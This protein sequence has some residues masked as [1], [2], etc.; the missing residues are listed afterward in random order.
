V[1]TWLEPQD[2]DLDVLEG[3][4]ALVLGYGNQGRAFA[5]N[6]RDS[7]LFE[8]VRV[9]V[10]PGGPSYSRAESDGFEVVD[11]TDL[12]TSDLLLC[13]LP[14]AV[15]EEVLGR[16]VE[17]R[18]RASGRRAG[19]C[20]AHGFSLVSS[21]LGERVRR[22][23]WGDVVLVAPVAPGEEVRSAFLEGRG[24][25]A[26]VGVWRDESGEALRLARALGHALGFS[27]AGMLKASIRDEVVVDL[28]GEQAV[29]CGGVEWLV[30]RAFDTLVQAGYSPEMAF[31]EC[32]HQLKYLA[33][34]VHRNGLEGMRDRV[35]EVAYYGALTRGPRVIDSQVARTMAEILDE[36][37]SGAFQK[38]LQ[39]IEVRE[40]STRREGEDGLIERTGREVRER[41]FRGNRHHV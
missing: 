30:R 37:E 21:S 22:A 25:P 13:L 11:E 12:G 16:L 24:V 10:R 9:W 38:E 18:L 40:L 19:L 29:V 23:P 20:V 36:I 3:K 4:Q 5:L 41:I 33:E 15:H 6:L 8:N 32:V 28:F 1:G 14:D 31:L 17:P 7:G 27:R 39:S 35:S 2:G 26:Y 34:L